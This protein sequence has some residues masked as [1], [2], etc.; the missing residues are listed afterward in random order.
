MVV[1][2]L[3]I[4][5]VINMFAFRAAKQKAAARYRRQTEVL[6]QKV[7]A[8]Q[9]A[10]VDTLETQLQS[11]KVDASRS[12][13][14]LES[15][16]ADLIL[17]EN[18]EDGKGG[19]SEKLLE[20]I[21]QAEAKR[22]EIQEQLDSP[23]LHVVEVLELFDKP[24]VESIDAKCVQ[25]INGNT[26]ECQNAEKEIFKVRFESIECPEITKPFGDTAM[27]RTAQLC[28][29]KNVEILLTG[30]ES[31]G[32]VVGFVIADETNLTVQLITEGLA[33][34][35]RKTSNSKELSTLEEKAKMEKRGLWADVD[36]AIAPSRDE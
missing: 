17:T 24:I 11:D 28:R 34:L 9:A 32:L 2:S 5:L 14:L 29:E 13:A 23:T 25:I 8:A 21:K 36:G 6:V 18:S 20:L 31:G 22:E 4:V 35:D 33:W 12:R 7:L 30:K 26:I 27:R 10:A 15:L 16:Q 3:A 19:P 1:T